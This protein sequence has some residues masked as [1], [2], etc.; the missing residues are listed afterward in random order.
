[1]PVKLNARTD[2]EWNIIVGQQVRKR[3]KERGYTR[4]QL[5]KIAG[6]TKSTLEGVEAGARGTSHNNL[7][8]IARALCCDMGYFYGPIRAAE[9]VVF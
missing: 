8:R 1:M 2:L 5:A 7:Y 4:W 6:V 3:R 9:S